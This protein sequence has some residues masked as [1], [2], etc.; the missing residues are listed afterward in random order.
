M[1]ERDELVAIGTFKKPHGIA[2]EISATL[3]C[4]FDMI[5]RFSCIICDIEG[6]Y[7]P[8]F[9]QSSRR[10]S[11]ETILLNID[12]I[13]NENEAGLLANKDVFVLKK[14]FRKLTTDDGLEEY[15]LDYFIGFHMKVH[16]EVIGEIVDIEDS[17]ANVLF[18]V[19]RNDK[20]ILIPAVEEF[21]EN[22]DLENKIIN[23]AIP[24]EL[25]KL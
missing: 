4:D 15:P 21:M 14:E 1:I 7:V 17:T 23:M 20:Q 5:K 24:D 25:L 13:Y 22:F 19:A 8:F 2:G 3:D 9:V 10:K 16:Q 12:G 6:V 18:V 11:T